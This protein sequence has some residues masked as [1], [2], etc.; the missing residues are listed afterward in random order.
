M[1]PKGKTG[2]PAPARGTK[3]T[4]GFG[5]VNV[6]V[7]L[8]PLTRSDSGRVAGKTLCSVHHSPIHQQSVCDDCGEVC[9]ETVIGYDVGGGY[10]IV[11]KDM[12]GADRTG[13]LELTAVLDVAAIDPLYFEKPYLVWPQAGHEAGFDLL[14]AS[15]R[16]SGKAAIG[17]TVMNK[18]TRAVLL[19]WSDTAGCLVAHTCTYDE[20]LAWTDVKLVRA[21]ADEREAPGEQLLATAGMLLAAI[22]TDSFDFETV[23]DEY[24][25]ELRAAIAAAAAGTPAPARKEEPAQAPV[26]D[27]MAALQASV[28]QAKQKPKVAA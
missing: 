7:K 19:R 10:V 23:T 28:A 20:R 18:A 11:D 14:V 8:A 22:E 4:V 1:P 17:T 26:V 3:L 24:D 2:A 12:L 16:S 21:A 27:L 9:E 25:A 13:R 15:L 6:D 5:L